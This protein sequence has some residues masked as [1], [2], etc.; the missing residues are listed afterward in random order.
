VCSV[1]VKL[2][3]IMA[4]IITALNTPM[5]VFLD[6]CRPI[7]LPEIKSIIKFGQTETGSAEEQPVEG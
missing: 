1:A 3:S 4:K 2:D 5:E 6:E 7:A